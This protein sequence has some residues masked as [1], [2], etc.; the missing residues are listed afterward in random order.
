MESARWSRIDG[1]LQRIEN[2]VACFEDFR[3]T[4]RKL[5]SSLSPCASARALHPRPPARLCLSCIICTN[6]LAHLPET[7]RLRI[8]ATMT[9]PACLP[10]A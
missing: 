8:S 5:S 3:A 7:V 4:A 10:G 6:A 9:A 1:E 2:G